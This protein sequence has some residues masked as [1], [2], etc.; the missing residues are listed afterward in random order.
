MNIRE[1]ADRYADRGS[2]PTQYAEVR[3]A[4]EAALKEAVREALAPVGP[5][6]DEVLQAGLDACADAQGIGHTLTAMAAARLS[7][8]EAPKEERR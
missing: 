2:F 3:A 6:S 8:L 5:W 1:I 7:E 4:I